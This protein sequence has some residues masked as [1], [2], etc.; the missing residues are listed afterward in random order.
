MAEM[1]EARMPPAM[2]AK[3]KHMLHSE[4]AAAETPRV[5]VLQ[6]ATAWK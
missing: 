5:R 2:K 4:L 3:M 6:K 1:M